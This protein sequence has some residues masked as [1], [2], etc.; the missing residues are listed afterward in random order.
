VASL[1]HRKALG[2]RQMLTKTLEWN[3]NFCI[4]NFVFGI[5]DQGKETGVKRAF[6]RD[7]QRPKLVAGLR[8]RFL[9]MGFVNLAL[10]PFILVF[11]LIYFFFKYGEVWSLICFRLASWLVECAKWLLSL[12]ALLF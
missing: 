3:L 10:A 9:L 4:S 5:H 7:V 1:S 12:F 6:L 8:R 11:L 2:G